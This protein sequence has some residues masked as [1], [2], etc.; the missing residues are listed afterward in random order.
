MELAEADC[1]PRKTMP[2]PMRGHLCEDLQS[3]RGTREIGGTCIELEAEGSRIALDVG[4]PPRRT[5]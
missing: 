1:P 2:E 3:D 5:G 4:L